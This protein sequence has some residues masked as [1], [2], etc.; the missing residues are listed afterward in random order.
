M[1]EY[2]E[3]RLIEEGEV[4]NRDDVRARRIRLPDPPEPRSEPPLA[5][6]H[7]RWSRL[8]ELEERHP[9]RRW[10]RERLTGHDSE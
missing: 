2:A 9:V 6:Q 10:V 3:P 5:E 4:F 7:E 1:N 8:E